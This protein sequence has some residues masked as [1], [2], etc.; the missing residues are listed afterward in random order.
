MI[1]DLF[2]G[3]YM[4]SCYAILQCYFIDQDLQSKNGGKQARNCPE[5]L[6]AFFEKG[7]EMQ[8]DGDDDK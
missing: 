6:K 7:N 1:A 4:T 5:Q 3:V 8:G 2:S